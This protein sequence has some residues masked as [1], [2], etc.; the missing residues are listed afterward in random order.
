VLVRLFD[1]AST[2][3]FHGF[4]DELLPGA[5]CVVS[6]AGSSAHA[7][8]VVDAIGPLLGRRPALLYPDQ[9]KKL[10][11]TLNVQARISVAENAAFLHLELSR[12]LRDD[13]QRD[14]ERRA[15]FVRAV[16]AGVLGPP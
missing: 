11:G 4:R 5:G 8:R 9:V 12:S 13:L 16:G 10:G 15:S 1:R 14:A 2:V 6:A 7:R 3:Q